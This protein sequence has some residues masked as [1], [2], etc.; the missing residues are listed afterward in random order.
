MC[1]SVQPYLKLRLLNM[2]KWVSKR[3]EM[4]SQRY[5]LPTSLLAPSIQAFVFQCPLPTLANNPLWVY[6]VVFSLWQCVAYDSNF[7]ILL[8]LQYSKGNKED[9]TMTYTI[10]GSVL[11]ITD[12]NLTM[13]I[14]LLKL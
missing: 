12:S 1:L 5:T 3:L 6:F 14:E 11:H 10:R 7:D 13:Y 4:H 2:E 9:I 8:Q